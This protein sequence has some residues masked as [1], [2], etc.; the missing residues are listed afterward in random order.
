LIG[1]VVC[2]EFGSAGF[3]G[4]ISVMNCIITKNATDGSGPAFDAPKMPCT[5]EAGAVGG[6]SSTGRPSVVHAPYLFVVDCETQRFTI[7]GPLAIECIDAWY[8][9]VDRASNAGRCVFCV[10]IA[11]AHFGEILEVG[12]ALGYDHWPPLTIVAPLAGRQSKYPDH[13]QQAD[14]DRNYLRRVLP[15]RKRYRTDWLGDIRKIANRRSRAS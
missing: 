6:R 8:H 15:T 14:K 7:E 12:R 1:E 4:G 9:E 3:V 2:P 5:E 11:E 13:E 10:P